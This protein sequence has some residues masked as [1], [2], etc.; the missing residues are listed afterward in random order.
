[1]FR[2]TLAL[3]AQLGAHPHCLE[4]RRSDLLDWVHKLRKILT[5]LSQSHAALA[6]KTPGDCVVSVLRTLRRQHISHTIECSLT[7]V[8]H[9]ATKTLSQESERM[10][11]TCVLNVKPFF[12]HTLRLV[13][14]GSPH[15]PAELKTVTNAPA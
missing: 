2:T 15:A 3:L 13:L 10:G 4:Q 1:M 14:V 12:S 7:W 8:S 5:S 6:M 9:N 11:Q